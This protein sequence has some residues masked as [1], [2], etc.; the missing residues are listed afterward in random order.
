M[1][2]LDTVSYFK[3]LIYTSCIYYVQRHKTAINKQQYNAN[4]MEKTRQKCGKS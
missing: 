1:Q 3:V 4:I 2:K